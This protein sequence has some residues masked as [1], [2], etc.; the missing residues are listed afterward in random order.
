MKN[1]KKRYHILVLI[2]LCLASSF[3]ACKREKTTILCGGGEEF[4]CPT[5]MFCDLGK[6]CGG[7]DK[8]GECHYIPDSC[9]AEDQAVCGCNDQTYT[10]ACYANAAAISVAYQGSCIVKNK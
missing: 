10:N 9:P 2:S 6:R 7:I 1:L 3:V 4:S 5:G 8:Y